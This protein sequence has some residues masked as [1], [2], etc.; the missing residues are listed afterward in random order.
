MNSHVRR[1]HRVL[2]RYLPGWLSV[3]QELGSRKLKHGGPG[4][5]LGMRERP[6]QQGF[7]PN[8]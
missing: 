1:Q 2:N 5:I 6:H 3:A 8:A 4:T 7:H